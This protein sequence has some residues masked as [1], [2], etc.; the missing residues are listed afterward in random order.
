M[1]LNVFFFFPTSKILTRL[2]SSKYTESPKEDVKIKETPSRSFYW[3][4][5]RKN[6]FRIQDSSPLF[7]YPDT[8]VKKCD[9]KA[10]KNQIIS[11]R[12]EQTHKHPADPETEGYGGQKVSLKW[13]QDFS[14]DQN[15][16]TFSVT[17]RT[18]YSNRPGNVYV[19]CG[20]REHH[21]LF[22]AGWLLVSIASSSAFFF[23]KHT[24]EQV[25]GRNEQRDA[26]LWPFIH[27]LLLQVWS[28]VTK[29]WATF[30][31][32]CQKLVGA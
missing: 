15:K 12:N 2:E 5:Q 20:Q 24:F 19:T 31:L 10:S 30:S 23:P 28:Q 25:R 7:K 3:M 4:L 29:R 17:A 21:S 14:Q 6:P 16:Q 26:A 1:L 11:V 22:T 9:F 32:S 27:L 18:F 13:C 8:D